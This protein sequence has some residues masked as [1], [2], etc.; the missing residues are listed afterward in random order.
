MDFQIDRWIRE[1][2]DGVTA[3]FQKRI[4]FI[5]IQG[6]QGRGEATASSDIDMVLILDKVS[7]ADL[8]TYDR[9]L[10]T[11]PNR[12]KVCGFVSGKD[13]IE[14]WDKSDLFQFCNDTTA[15]YGS[16]DE[17]LGSV[18]WDVQ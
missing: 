4:W 5:G 12:D 2:V 14:N 15:I 10:S 11:L 18:N 17:L 7:Y 9:L 8:Q 1:Y 3:S 13:E 16:L 6:S